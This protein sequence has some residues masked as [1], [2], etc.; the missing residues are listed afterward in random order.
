[1]R[2]RLK[3]PSSRILQNHLFRRR[4]KKTS[5]LRLTGL[6]EGN[7]PVTGEFLSQRASNPE[8]VSIWWRHHGLSPA[9]PNHYLDQCWLVVNWTVG[10]FVEMKFKIFIQENASENM[11]CKITTIL[12]GLNMLT[13]PRVELGIKKRYWK[14]LTSN[15]APGR[16]TNWRIACVLTRKVKINLRKLT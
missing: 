3:S 1:M 14:I 8:N 6:C 11:F 10:D 9:Q 2:W 15:R 16:N 4:W 13:P 12:F 7:S 5:K